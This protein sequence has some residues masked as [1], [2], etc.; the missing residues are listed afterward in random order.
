MTAN[1]GMG[2]N[3]AVDGVCY[4]INDLLQ[5]VRSA[6]A[7][8][9]GPSTKELQGVFERYEAKQRPRAD[10]CV[11]MSGYAVRLETMETWWLRALL[12][13]IPWVPTKWKADFFYD[14]DHSA[15]HLEFLPIPQPAKQD[16]YTD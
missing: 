12:Y 6:A 16:V 1:L 11:T 15:P 2:G 14:F 5:V 10:F 4:L 7:S 8:A 3:C 9:K 13:V